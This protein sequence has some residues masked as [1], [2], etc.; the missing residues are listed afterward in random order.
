MQKM[1]AIIQPEKEYYYYNNK[2]EYLN[3]Y[4]MYKQNDKS[5]GNLIYIKM[6]DLLAHLTKWVM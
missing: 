5:Q 6:F 2:Q 4:K 3:T 1:D